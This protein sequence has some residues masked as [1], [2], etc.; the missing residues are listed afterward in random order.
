MRAVD[1]GCESPNSASGPSEGNVEVPR[2]HVRRLGGIGE[3]PRMRRVALRLGPPSD[4]LRRRGPDEQ[5]GPPED[6]QAA[7]RS[8]PWRS[9]VGVRERA[10]GRAKP[11]HSRGREAKRRSAR[12]RR[13]RREPD[14]VDHAHRAEIVERVDVL[15]VE[16][17]PQV[18]ARWGRR[19]RGLNPTGRCPAP[20]P[21]VAFVDEE[22]GEERARGQ[23]PPP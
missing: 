16:A 9:G 22:R 11:R 8:R 12:E 23:R 17:D 4:R 14:Q 15:A 19:R 18:N 20:G 3:E 7:G 6:H 5:P 10:R 2:L 1:T 21:Q 13:D